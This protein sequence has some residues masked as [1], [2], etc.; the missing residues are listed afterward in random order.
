MPLAASAAAP[1]AAPPPPQ[2]P[3]AKPAARRPAWQRHPVFRFLASLRLAVILLSTLIV[4][5]A[6]GTIYESGF[7]ADV[8]RAYVYGAAWFNLWLILLALNLAASAFSRWPW[9]RR[10]TGFLLTHL[11]IIILLAGAMIG[12]LTGIE[13]TMTLHKNRPLD[14]ALVVNERQLY[15]VE[16]GT[17]V[18]TVFPVRVLGHRYPTPERP[19][20]LGRAASSGWNLELVGYS[21]RLAASFR[22]APVPDVAGRPAVHV[23]FASPRLGRSSEAWLLADSAENSSFDLGLAAVTVRRGVAPV[24]SSPGGP[25]GTPDERLAASAAGGLTVDEAVV[26]F[27]KS[28]A[29]TISQPSPGTVPSGATVRLTVNGGRRTVT[30]AWRGAEWELDAADTSLGRD[31]DLGGSG[32]TVRVEGFWPDFEMRDGKPATRSEEPRE[33]AVIVRL[34]GR[35]PAAGGDDGSTN[36][37]PAATTAV[38]GADAGNGLS[39]AGSGNRAEVFCDDAGNLTYTLNPGA[40]RGTLTAGQAVATGW[41]DW[42]LTVAEVLPHAVEAA[43]FQPLA[44]GQSP[45]NANANVTEGV[46]VRATPPAG[47][48]GGSPREQWVALGFPGAL[49][50]GGGANPAGR[51]DLI[52][53]NRLEPLPIGLQLLNFEVARNEGTNE[54]AGFKSSL[55]VTDIEGRSNEGAC[56]MNQPHNFPDRWWHT[57]TGLTY[58][59][60]QAK[61]VEGDLDQ[62]TV[63]VLRDPGWLFKWLGSTLVCA[64]VFCMFYLRP[65]RKPGAVLATPPVGV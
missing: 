3:A 38:A 15:V 53:G 49:D 31:E 22:P 27:A 65:A 26:A 41:A 9:Q 63:Q 23:R 32:L 61:F 12:R 35:L 29:R 28:P 55:R 14:N 24:A 6:V 10:H 58:K 4:A 45:A 1:V 33:P 56:S 5:S 11:G 50:G 42:Q 13:G 21:P 2:N 7:D 64:G 43:D 16:P 30:V 51:T 44:E 54:P 52:Y 62:S 19:W 59:I 8:A 46:R 20:P 40:I 34:R 18:P 60:S 39:P 17:R 37:P 36:V 25:S 48:S 57:W 47:A